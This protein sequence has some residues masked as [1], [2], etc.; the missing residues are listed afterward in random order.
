[1]VKIS[2][3]PSLDWA[4]LVPDGTI[5]PGYYQRY[6]IDGG[7]AYIKKVRSK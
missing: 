2:V 6:T 1:M 5:A 4:G 7:D 3:N